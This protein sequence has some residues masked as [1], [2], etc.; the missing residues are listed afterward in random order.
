MFTNYQSDMSE[1]LEGADIICRENGKTPPEDHPTEISPELLT[2]PWNVLLKHPNP[3]ANL[4]ES[5]HPGLCM[6]TNF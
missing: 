5:R 2:D 4:T 6:G 1:A 3:C